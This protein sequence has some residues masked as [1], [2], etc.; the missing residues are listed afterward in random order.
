MTQ[1]KKKLHYGEYTVDENGNDIEYYKYLPYG[2]VQIT[3]AA[4]ICR[5]ESQ[6]GNNIFFQ[7]R[8]L[9]KESGMYYYRARYYAPNLGRFISIDPILF[10]QSLNQYTFVENN[11]GTYNDPTGHRAHAP[12]IKN[13]STTR[14]YLLQ[15][16]DMRSEKVMKPARTYTDQKNKVYRECGKKEFRKWFG[17]PLDNGR[18][19]PYTNRRHWAHVEAN[20]RQMNNE[21]AKGKRH[22]KCLDENG[23]R[24]RAGTWRRNIKFLNPYWVQQTGRPFLETSVHTMIHETAHKKGA[25][26]RGKEYVGDLACK[27]LARHKPK[28]AKENADSYAEFIDERYYETTYSVHDVRFNAL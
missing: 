12:K 17:C 21:F 18:S 13:C 2:Q 11:P 6:V 5:Q 22:Y 8:E 20:I 4:G 24:A 14:T 19:K 3:D 10:D 27:W 25:H 9:D 15:V 28:I 1:K 23:A 16:I 7:S 26:F